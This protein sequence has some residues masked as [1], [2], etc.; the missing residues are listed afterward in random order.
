MDFCLVPLQEWAALD[1]QDWDTRWTTQSDVADSWLIPVYEERLIPVYEKRLILVYESGSFLYMKSGSFLYMKSSSFLYMKS[2]SFLYMKSGSFLYMESGT[3]H[4]W[5]TSETRSS[6]TGRSV[7]L[8]TSQ[9][10]SS[11][12]RM[13]S[14]SYTGLTCVSLVSHLCLVTLLIIT[15]R[16]R[17][18]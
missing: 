16:P 5:G 14:S 18:D 4:L 13:K 6:Y 1:I 12:L 10:K 11:A 3:R 9:H 7:S 2:G 15:Y 17:I 8:V